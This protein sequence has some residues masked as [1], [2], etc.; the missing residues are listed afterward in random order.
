MITF[1]VK[2]YTMIQRKLETVLKS[3]IGKGKAIILIGAR[4]VGKSTLFDSIMKKMED[5]VLSLNC[6][7]AVVRE[8]LANISTTNLK[9][10]LGNRKIVL[11]DEAQ[12]V[13]NIGMVIKR[14]V[15]NYSDVQVLVTGSSTLGIK[16][17]INEPL[18]G[19]KFEYE[20]YPISTGELYDTYGLIH[21][22]QLLENRLIFGSY[23]DVLMHPEDAK[24]I[25][26]N[27]SDSY[28]YKDILELDSVRKP[29]LLRKFLIAIALQVGSEVSYNELAST[30]GSD[31]KTVERYVDLLEKCFVIFRLTAL[32]RN[33]RNELKKSKKIFFY[34][35]GIRNAILNN[36]APSSL[37]NDMGSL[38][39]N[40][41]IMERIKRNKYLG[42]H[43]NYYF[44]RT[45]D[46][47]EI[48]FIEEYDGEFTIFEMKWNPRNKNSKFPQAFLD[49][50]R[51]RE[52]AVVTPDNYLEFLIQP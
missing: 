26:S 15:D 48:D 39:E 6:D 20:M 18:T 34:D 1:V 8:T 50:Y 14:I 12:R 46:Q 17:R 16:D 49:A 7:D 36:Y 19:R 21:T 24:E 42:E 2:N 41:F 3:R 30:V 51:C 40:F 44:W 52:M 43:R 28:L 10:L 13:E 31:A 32:S 47:K 35:T 9:L 5:P 23:P 29:D 37:R 4:Q 45:T 38:W 22:N 11:I 33:L 27:L 25:L